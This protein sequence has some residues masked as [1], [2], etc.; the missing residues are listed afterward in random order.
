MST[1]S[2][3]SRLASKKASHLKQKSAL[4]KKRHQKRHEFLK[5]RARLT[6]CN[7]FLIEQ[8]EKKM[9]SCSQNFPILPRSFFIVN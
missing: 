5:P 3:V 4:E 9:D 7:G 8:V 1:G 6:A 2:P